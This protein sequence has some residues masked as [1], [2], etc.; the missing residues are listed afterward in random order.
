M[1]IRDRWGKRIWR[2]PPRRLDCVTEPAKGM[3]EEF[4]A[5]S[6]AQPVMAS[7]AK[8]LVAN[9]YDIIA[10]AY[11]KQ[12]ARSAVRDHWLGQL[13][14]LLPQSARVLDLGCGAGIPVARELAT[15]GF[16]VVG[17][18]GSA[19]QVQLAR[20]N[21]PTA[22]FLQ[23]DMT[24]VQFASASFD[25]VSAFY[26]ITHIPRNEHAGLLRRI[27][28]WLPPRGVFVASLGAGQ[29]C[30]WRGDWLGVEMFFSHFGAETNEQLLRDA[31]F[32]IEQAELVE[33]DNED[34]RFL[35]IVARV[36]T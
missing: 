31:G 23:A 33:Q 14:A 21:V 35:W 5:T 10:E 11:L 27:A 17:I 16:Q 7:D 28:T 34:A 26:S 18:D 32:A 6:T 12:Y 15:R 24:A 19:R 13:I 3:H 29:L 22:E 30:D 36:A 25:A 4:D 9:G 20:G 8:S 1:N 2:G